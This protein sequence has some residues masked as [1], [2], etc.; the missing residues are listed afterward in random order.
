LS[1][2]I[3]TAL[4]DGAARETMVFAVAGFVVGGL[5]DLV[6]DLAYFTRAAW[7]WRTHGPTLDALP[8][9]ERPIA[10]F[11]PAWDEAA[12]IGPM[13][14]TA[15]SRWPHTGL[16]IYVGAYPNDRATISAIAAVAVEDA[17]VR[18]VI[19]DHPGPTTKADCLN[20]LWAAMIA[21]ETGGLPTAAAVVLHDAE[22]VVH[23][24]E[25]A[26]FDH[27]IG[28]Y[29]AVQLPV[30]PLADARSRW[31][32][33]TYIDEFSESHAKQLVVRQ[34][35]GAGMP[36]AGVGCAIERGMLGRIAVARDGKPFDA[37]SH[38]E[39]YELGLTIASMGGRAAAAR[40]PEQRGGP[41]VAV[42][43]YFPGGL[44]AAIRQRSRWMF[45]IAL[46]G[47]DRV[48]W[49]G[50][51][52]LGDYWMRMRDRRQ[53]LALIVLAV[54]YAGVILTAL[55]YGRTLF[56]GTVPQAPDGWLKVALTVS[57]ALLLWRAAMRA[58]FVT[59]A[60]GWREGVRS[61]PRMIVGNI[62]ALVAARRA[63]F[64]YM[65]T[66]RGARPRWDKT[67]HRFPTAAELTEPVA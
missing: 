17:R 61:A 51:Y 59:Y 21:E 26:V 66:L 10:I 11:V 24:G 14:R 48:G 9:P 44:D 32:G 31:I 8:A 23:A 38:T 15:L 37:E 46:A 64:R 56:G 47:W 16:R 39:D 41:L 12:V 20:S 50:A 49:R 30:L 35:I 13:L 65:A 52:G 42:H 25:L 54:A 18:L 62:I 60:Y 7:R 58:G 43:A 67:D 33:G 19:C 4:I 22:D 3:V 2:G 28:R 5:D 1:G 63:L 53:P 57:F 55:S 45:G 27:L 40:I 36:F 29:D 6:V 34:A